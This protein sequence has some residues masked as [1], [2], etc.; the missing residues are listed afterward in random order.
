MKPRLIS[1]KLESQKKRGENGVQ[2]TSEER[3]DENL[4]QF[5]KEIKLQIQDVPQILS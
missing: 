5:I 4:S 2:A 3:I 1:M